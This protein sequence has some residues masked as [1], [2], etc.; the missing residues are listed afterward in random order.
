MVGTLVRM[1]SSYRTHNLTMKTRSGAP[2]KSRGQVAFLHLRLRISMA[3]PA[4]PLWF[5]M[6]TAT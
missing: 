3:L 1:A 6:K 5:M 2:W 4:M